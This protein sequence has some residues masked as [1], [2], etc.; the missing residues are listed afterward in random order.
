MSKKP[1]ITD[2]EYVEWGH[3]LSER[4]LLI[5]PQPVGQLEDSALTMSRKKGVATPR[6][7]INDTGVF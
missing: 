2:K 3:N 6:L 7:T 1:T 4:Y 5:V